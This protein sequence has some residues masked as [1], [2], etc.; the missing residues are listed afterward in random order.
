MNFPQPLEE[1]EAV[2]DVNHMA[3]VALHTLASTADELAHM[4][5][6]LLRAD[7]ARIEAAHSTLGLV[8]QNLKAKE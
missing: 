8:L 7:L 5:P 4:D 6:R 2:I 3:G 1:R